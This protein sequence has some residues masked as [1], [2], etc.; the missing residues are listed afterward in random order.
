MKS[1]A[2][3]IVTCLAVFAGCR[4]DPAP[5][6]QRPTTDAAVPSS[7]DLPPCSPPNVLIVGPAEAP[8]DTTLVMLHGYGANAADIEPVARALAGAR[9]RLAVVVP[10]G[11]DP[12]ESTPGGRQWWGFR[13]GVDRDRGA[14]L[15]TAAL[16]VSRFVDAELLRRGLPRDKV[17][18][19]GFSQ[20]AML[21]Q[22]MAVHAMPPPLAVVSFSG[23][24]DDD[25]PIGAPVTTP[26]L[27][28]HG[29]RDA[30][31]PFAESERA[32][33]AL[34]ARG[35]RVERVDRPVMAH[36][37]DAESLA[38]AVAFLARNLGAR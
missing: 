34:L 18:W 35:A 23:R 1:H 2:I 37:I 19:A 9:S 26:V 38:A 4:A 32:E 36:A 3:P 11:C 24:F 16:R 30:T 22:W 10:D 25:S 33:R 15:K 21:S 13:A 7:E 20:G 14:H 31:I 28:V 12:S 6:L 5:V 29:A 27:L 17:A 8:A